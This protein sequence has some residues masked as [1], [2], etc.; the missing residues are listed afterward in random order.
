MLLLSPRPRFAPLDV[1]GLVGCVGLPL[2]SYLPSSVLPEVKGKVADITKSLEFGG[3]VFAVE[4]AA[5]D[6]LRQCHLEAGRQ[7]GEAVRVGIAREVRLLL[8]RVLDMKHDIPLYRYLLDALVG[9][10]IGHVVTCVL[11]G[12]Y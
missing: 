7:R 10:L 4:A 2:G 12:V 1:F 8:E 6:H 5:V 3:I 11:L 9:F